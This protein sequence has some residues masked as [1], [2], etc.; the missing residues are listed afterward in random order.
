MNKSTQLV[1]LGT[2]F[3]SIIGVFTACTKHEICLPTGNQLYKVDYYDV[4]ET[5]R[6]TDSYSYSGALITNIESTS[7]NSTD[8]TYNNQKQVIRTD[9]TLIGVPF[10]IAYTTIDYYS[11]GSIKNIKVFTNNA[12]GVTTTPSITSFTWAAAKLLR[13]DVQYTNPSTNQLEFSSTYNYTYSGDNVSKC[14]FN[15]EIFV[16]PGAV[17]KDSLSFEYDNNPNFI[18]KD[19]AY[20][21]FID[22]FPNTSFTTLRTILNPNPFFTI[23]TDRLEQALSYC[24]S[25]NRNNIVKIST[26]D[27][28]ISSIIDYSL[29][30]GILASKLITIKVDGKVTA[31]YFYH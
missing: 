15:G 9:H 26:D 13:V 17:W 5:Y 11:D 23:R 27:G 8:L 14:V 30:T 29:G 25:L 4:S 1:A 16:A 2:T 22:M 3:L 20:S 31:K 21:F 28:A 24:F 10:P 18:R 12:N 6:A 7:A 19:N